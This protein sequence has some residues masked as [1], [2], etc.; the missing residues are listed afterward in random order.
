MIINNS[1]LLNKSV[2]IPHA[3][4]QPSVGGN[5]PTSVAQLNAFIDEKEYEFLVMTLGFEKAK[6]VLDNLA[7]PVSP[8]TEYTINPAAPQW[9]KDLINGLTYSDGTKRWQGLRYTIGT[10]KL[11]LIAYYVFFYWLGE[12]FSNYST[13]GVQV[14]QSEN[15]IRQ[16]PN[17]KQVAAW[18][19]FAGM[20]NGDASGNRWLNYSF[21]SNWNR[22]G[23]RWSGNS[24]SLTEVSLYR[25]MQDNDFDMQYFTLQ[26]GINI[27]NL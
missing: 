8:A 25:F 3:V 13:T 27:Y 26:G 23:M 19:K 11:S 1:Y 16:L 12:D 21:F 10:Q 7:A 6:V 14:P 2:F 24:G 9:V 4:A 5:A 15:S 22:L 18:N 17:G 20:Y